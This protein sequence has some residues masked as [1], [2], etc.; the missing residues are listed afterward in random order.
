MKKLAIINVNLQY[1]IPSNVDV[2]EYLENIELPKQYVENS[3]KLVEIMKYCP[4]C[5]NYYSENTCNSCW[6]LKDKN[7][8]D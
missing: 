4:H 3:F 8:E 7:L 2:T 6:E 5:K 1:E